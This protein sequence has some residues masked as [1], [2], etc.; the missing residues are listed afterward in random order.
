MSSKLL[1]ALNS[2]RVPEG[3][4]RLRPTG[5]YNAKVASPIQAPQQPSAASSLTKLADIGDSLYASYDK[6]RQDK[7]DE[8]SDEIIRK[9]TP[10]QRRMA[11]Q[12][13]TLLYQDD[14]YAMQ[15]LHLK[16]GRNAAFL[17]DDEVS[18]KIKEGAFRTRKEMED[19]RAKRLQESAK[20]FAQ[21]FGIN[22]DNPDYQKGF[23]AD[24]T[25]RNIALYGAHDSFLSD[26]AK[27]G[28]LLN[29]RVEIN[30]LL[31]DPDV[32]KAPEGGLAFTRYIDQGLTNGS[33]PS[34]D[35]ALSTISQ[36]LSDVV[37][38]EGGTNFLQNIANHKV[39]LYGKTSTY[40]ELLGEDQW[41]N[42]E[43]TA[44]QNEFK[45]NSQRTED[46][47]I[48]LNSALNQGNINTSW[49]QL[50]LIKAELN[51]VQPG[52]QMTPQ[53]ASLIEA[54]TSL[55]NRMRK[56]TAERAA[57]LDAERKSLNKTIVLD[58]IF[59]KKIT[60]G[61]PTV[62]TLYTDIP[63]NESTGAFTKQDMINFAQRKLS[64]IDSLDIPDAAKDRMKLD[65][66]K[67]DSKFGPFR[68]RMGDLVTSAASEWSAS[69]ING[70][71]LDETP[72]LDTLRRIRNVDPNLFAQLYPD[73]AE[74]FLT[75]DQ[76]DKQGIDSQI[77][78]DAD[79]RRQ[80][81]TKEMQYEADHNW[82]TVI[83]NNSEY[84][85]LAF[86]PTSVDKSARKIYES[87]LY[88]TGNPNMAT[89]HMLKH[90][91][92]TTHTFRTTNV[93]GRSYGMVSKN[94][95]MVSDDPNSWEQ[96]VNIMETAI[97]GIQKTNPWITNGQL[98][99]YENRDGSITLMDTTGTIRLR[100]DK[101]LLSRMFREN[102]QKVD[103]D[104]RT[105][106]LKKVKRKES[107]S[108]RLKAKALTEYYKTRR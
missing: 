8:R 19:Y 83:K 81:Q 71:L 44:Q 4:Q 62:S 52:T 95:L 99:I 108:D 3:I 35:Q 43:V 59:N 23:N 45:L 104:A 49:E 73:N 16:S 57:Q 53:R 47:R 50:Q 46:F 64:E 1:Q 39:N 32:L 24:I 14:P 30:S 26:Q 41:N 66:V 97:Q 13:G 28:S 60:E 31:S 80:S 107:A 9:L 72:S 93:D 75:L 94:S 74:L 2:I 51:R 102:Q 91:S 48:R 5:R 63:T 65:Y 38:K 98:S 20:S 61:D 88:R 82:E 27:K 25:A 103:T 21:E 36:S 56:E 18:T 42:L 54:E 78:I 40:K 89:Q 100:Y 106:A 86:M 55:Q 37:N 87:I 79:K 77:L 69:V 84:P 15:A 10:E 34:D 105:K 12:N 11:I 96:G 90:L 101:D 92:E 85:E 29:T 7:A 76:L 58:N 68:T 22:E 67:A 70:K 33:I 6:S 17:V